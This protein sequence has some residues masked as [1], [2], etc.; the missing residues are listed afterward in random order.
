MS[1]ILPPTDGSEP[2]ARALTAVLAQLSAT[3]VELTALTGGATA[4]DV[5]AEFARATAVE[6]AQHFP[7]LPNQAFDVSKLGSFTADG[8]GFR[9]VPAPDAQKR[10]RFLHV[11]PVLNR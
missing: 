10:A 4:A 1:G 11:A 5:L 9:N 8:E 2:T 3:D 6:L 7:D